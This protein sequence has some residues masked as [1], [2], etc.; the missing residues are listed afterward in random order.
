[1]CF[2]YRRP[3][4]VSGIDDRSSAHGAGHAGAESNQGLYLTSAS[5]IPKPISY[6]IGGVVTT[7]MPIEIIGREIERYSL[8]PARI[9]EFATG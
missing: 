5:A 4:Y 1:M 2:S 3:D 9:V 6:L 8:G 7:A